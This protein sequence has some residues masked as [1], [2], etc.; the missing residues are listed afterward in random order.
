MV[1]EKTLDDLPGLRLWATA[2]RRWRLDGA[3]V[4]AQHGL[5]W[6]GFEILLALFDGPRRSGQLCNELGMTTGGMAKLLKRLEE[7]DLIKRERGANKDLRTVTVHLTEK[8]NALVGT[9]GLDIL[10]MRDA[11][12]RQWGISKED[13]DAITD[14]WAKLREHGML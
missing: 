13:E 9:A 3:E 12:Y 6:S 11:D 4:L 8:G 1:S 14:I 2:I 10:S 5:T 7:Q